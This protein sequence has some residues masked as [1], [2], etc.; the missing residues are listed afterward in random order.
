MPTEYIAVDATPTQPDNCGPDMPVVQNGTDVPIPLAVSV[1]FETKA[2]L[3][4]MLDYQTDRLNRL[5]RLGDTAGAE[6]A[7]RRHK[8]IWD[9]IERRDAIAAEKERKRQ[10]R[11]RTAAAIFH[12][13]GQVRA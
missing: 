7:D 11:M 8:I 4:R 1:R 6:L 2:A 5:E 10:A 9:E 3:Y 12:E 13:T